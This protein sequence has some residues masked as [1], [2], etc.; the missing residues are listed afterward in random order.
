MDSNEVKLGFVIVLGR[1]RFKDA[2]AVLQTGKKYFLLKQ[3]V[4][5]YNSLSLNV[6][7]LEP[8]LFHPF[9]LEAVG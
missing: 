1:H 5:S 8:F 2:Q 7:Q 6:M 4:S 3:G 9:S